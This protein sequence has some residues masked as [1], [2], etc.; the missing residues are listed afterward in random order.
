MRKSEGMIG[1][2]VLNS[3]K[4]SDRRGGVLV[5]HSGKGDFP[6][7]GFLG[8]KCLVLGLA[9]AGRKGSLR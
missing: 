6:G 1:S 3:A 2:N 7:R 4:E 8:D 5:L 9:G